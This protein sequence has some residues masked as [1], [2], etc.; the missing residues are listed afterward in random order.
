MLPLVKTSSIKKSFSLGSQEQ[1][2][3]VDVAN[4]F[5]LTRAPGSP[6]SPGRPGSP[7]PPLGPEEPTGPLSPWAPCFNAKQN[8][9]EKKRKKET[10]QENKSKEMQNLC[11]TNQSTSTPYKHLV[12]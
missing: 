8:V 6:G 5:V 11:F 9:S 4:S 7:W 2:S 10:V 3:W 12:R 1:F